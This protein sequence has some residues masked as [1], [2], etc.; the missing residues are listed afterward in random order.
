MQISFSPILAHIRPIIRAKAAHHAIP[1]Y[2]PQAIKAT[3][4]PRGPVPRI[5]QPIGGGLHGAEPTF[6]PALYQGTTTAHAPPVAGHP[7]A[8]NQQRHF[9]NKKTPRRSWEQRGICV[10]GLIVVRPVEESND[11]AAIAHLVRGEY[12]IAA[13]VNADMKL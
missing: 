5:F 4:S 9:V 6:G 12:G 7:W 1:A 10:I 2:G 13:I 11:L 8:D 3:Q